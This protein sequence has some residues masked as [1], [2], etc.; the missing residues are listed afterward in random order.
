MNDVL[1][2]QLIFGAASAGWA[3]WTWR[4]TK[5]QRRWCAVSLFCLLLATMLLLV[6]LEYAYLATTLVPTLWW[7]SQTAGVVMQLRLQECTQRQRLTCWSAVTSCLL[8]RLLCDICVRV[9]LG[10]DR[11]YALLPLG[12]ELDD[13]AVATQFFASVVLLLA[14]G[15]QAKHT[16]TMTLVIALS[17]THCFVAVGRLL[18]LPLVTVVACALTCVV[19]LVSPTLQTVSVPTEAPKQ[20]RVKQSDDLAH[21]YGHVATLLQH[22]RCRQVFPLLADLGVLIDDVTVTD[23]V[24]GR[25]ASGTVYTGTWHGSQVAIKTVP[26]TDRRAVL[27]LFHEAVVLTRVRHPNIVQLIGVT[28]HGALVLE[29]CKKRSLRSLIFGTCD[30]FRGDR[31]DLSHESYSEF[32]DNAGCHVHGFNDRPSDHSDHS[33]DQSDH[34]DHQDDRSE[35]EPLLARASVA[36]LRRMS[37]DTFDSANCDTETSTPG[38][39]ADNANSV[40]VPVCWIG[41]L[42]LAAELCSALQC[43][44]SAKVLHRDLKPANVLLSERNRV[45]LSDF[46][47][48]AMY[49]SS[50]ENHENRV[51]LDI[52]DYDKDRL[53]LR[54]R[55]DTEPPPSAWTQPQLLYFPIRAATQCQQGRRF[56]CA[57]PAGGT[58]VYLAPETRLRWEYS[59]KSDVYSLGATLFE[60]FARR[61]FQVPLQ[62][63]KFV[64]TAIRDIVEACL[65]QEPAKR[66]SCRIVRQALTRLRRRSIRLQRAANSFFI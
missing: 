42:R 64:P 1:V 39:T 46:G 52:T 9:R 32:C 27:Q 28:R 8:G 36:Q 18:Q 7:T 65:E 34:P 26:I 29:R 13:Y 49:D 2:L 25:G 21:L 20:R 12:V 16:A 50:G 66:P 23:R 58:A 11:A 54:F 45:K 56:L 35:Q 14:A 33:S 60:L 10:S 59:T 19:A 3:V 48:A 37:I 47:L 4:S 31:S 51:V 55:A 24:V 41:V 15:T 17:L 61:A 57:L 43:L 30:G 5:C 62:W 44:H 6:P 22:R 40:T 38:N 63:P 53:P